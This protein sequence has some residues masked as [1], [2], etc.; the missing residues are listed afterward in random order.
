VGS[1][2]T[3]SA[4]VVSRAWNTATV[5]GD[6]RRSETLRA[7]SFWWLAALLVTFL[8]GAA[9]P[10]PLYPIYQRAF[11]FSTLTITA[12]Y[13]AYAVGGIIGLVICGQLSD[14]IGRRPVVVVSIVTQVLALAAFFIATGEAMLYVARIL[15]GLGIGI[16]LGALSAWLV[17]LQPPTNPR[18]G[19]LIAGM[20]AM[21]GLGLG[22]VGS[23]LLVE[24]APDPTHLVYIVFAVVYVIGLAGAALA[25]DVSIRRP[26][27][28]ASLAPDVGVS[29]SA[30]PLFISYLP[31][32]VAIWGLA[33][34]FLSLGPTLAISLL[35]RPSAA[36][37][38][39]VIFLL[40]GVGAVTALVLREWDATTLVARGSAVVIAGVILTLIGIAIGQGT[41]LFAGAFVAGLGFGP[42][43]SAIVRS[44]V[45]LAPPD[46]RAALVAA[47]YIGVYASFSIPA[48]VAGVFSS[49]VGLRTTA[50]GYGLIV[51][52]LAAITTLLLTRRQRRSAVR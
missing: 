5:S 26:N 7:V 46:R 31:S 21:L 47:I 3:P 4:F 17:D 32:L 40:L 6:V 18:L 15:Q 36:A 30:R 20:S 34:L 50:Y 51:G 42:A 10:S 37:G 49:V 11:G 19:G 27:W 14:H 45:P 16:G 24:F 8:A 38:G 43:F 13:A 29:P 12:I 1:N 44:L 2:P 39:L 25:P 41:V 22:A 9:A 48:V 35:D 52:L 28:F 23:G 33:G